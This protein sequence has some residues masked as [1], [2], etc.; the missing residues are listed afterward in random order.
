LSLFCFSSQVIPLRLNFSVVDDASRL[1]NAADDEYPLVIRR[2]AP[3]NQRIEQTPSGRS[4]STALAKKREEETCK[5]RTVI[6]LVWLS[7]VA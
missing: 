7:H 6:S 3:H 1:D 2:K 5:Q 4:S